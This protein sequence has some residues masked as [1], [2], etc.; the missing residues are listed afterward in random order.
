M[1]GFEPNLL[2]NDR[3]QT[4]SRLRIGQHRKWSETYEIFNDT[5][6]KQWLYGELYDPVKR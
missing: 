4:L 5:V 6:K 2:G 3:L 1:P